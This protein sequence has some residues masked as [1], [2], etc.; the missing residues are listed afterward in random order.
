LYDITSIRGVKVG[1]GEDRKAMSGVTVVLLERPSVT[2]CDARGGWPGSYD[3]ASIE[4]GKTFYRKQAI[5]LTGGDVF[6][7]D[8]GSGIRKFLVEKKIAGAVAGDMPEVVGTNIY[9]L[10]FA[11]HGESVDYAKLGY[12]AC[13]SASSGRVKQGNVGVG[14][15]A[16]VGKLLAARYRWKGGLGT[17]ASR[18]LGDVIVGALVATN[19]VGNIFDPDTGRTIAGTRKPGTKGATFCEFEEV[20]PDYVRKSVRR[21]RDSRATTV[22][23]VVTNLALTHEQAFKVAQMAHDGLARVIRPVH[24]TT[25]GDTIFAVSTGEIAPNLKEFVDYKLLDA[26]GETSARQVSLAVLNAVRH[27]SPLGG[28]PGLST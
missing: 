14:L 24:A 1:H 11:K 6:G 5:F 2:A 26:V 15:G 25:D 17:S 9:D 18:I 13:Q 7:Y 28:L 21:K 16:T 22:G 12:K 23:V 19:A 4:V 27:A 8:T 3:T 10:S 20:L